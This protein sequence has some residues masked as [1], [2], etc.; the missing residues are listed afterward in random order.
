MEEAR[1]SFFDFGPLVFRADEEWDGRYRRHQDN[2]QEN[3]K[4]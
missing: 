1:Q 2:D 3:K 4:R